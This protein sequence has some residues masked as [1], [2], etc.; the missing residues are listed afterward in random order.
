MDKIDALIADLEAEIAA[1]SSKNVWKAFEGLVAALAEILPTLSQAQKSAHEKALQAPG[2]NSLESLT[3][4]FKLAAAA[5]GMT[6]AGL[7]SLLMALLDAV[8]PLLA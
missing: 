2:A 8:K 6:L 5:P 7:F 1:P 3:G 4:Q